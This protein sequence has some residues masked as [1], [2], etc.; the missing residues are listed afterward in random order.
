MKAPLPTIA[1]VGPSCRWLPPGVWK[2][3]LDF[4]KEQYAQVDAEMWIS[5]LDTVHCLSNAISACSSLD[6]TCFV[7]AVVMAD[8]NSNEITAGAL[9]PHRSID[10]SSVR[11]GRLDIKTVE[12]PRMNGAQKSGCRFD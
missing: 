8:A 4:F 10:L 9:L 1:G 2:T 7:C 12:L 6:L 3:V 5:H 11:G